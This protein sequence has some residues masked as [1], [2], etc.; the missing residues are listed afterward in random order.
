M[1]AR[2][3][4][5]F[6]IVIWLLPFSMFATIAIHFKFMHTTVSSFCGRK[7]LV[8]LIAYFIINLDMSYITEQSLFLIFRNHLG[9]LS[10]Q[11]T[12]LLKQTCKNTSVNK[13]LIQIDHTMR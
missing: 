5:I 8:N 6:V 9:M 7:R 13:D 10:K 2:V 4:F 12:K 3:F 11:N 1:T